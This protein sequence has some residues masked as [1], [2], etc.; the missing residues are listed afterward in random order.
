M[1]QGAGGAQTTATLAYSPGGELE[2]LAVTTSSSGTTATQFLYD[3]D[4]MVGEYN[5]GVLLRRYVRGAD[6]DEPLVWYDASDGFQRR[7]LHADERGSIIGWS[8]GSGVMR[9]TFT[10]GPYGEPSNWAGTRFAYTGQMAIPEVALYHDKAR[11]YDP[12]FGHF[13]QTD[14]IRYEGGAN[15]YQ[16]VG[17]DPINEADPTGDIQ[18][19]HMQW[20]AL[21]GRFFVLFT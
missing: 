5:S 2:Q 20:I 10:Y 7:W 12:A 8:D 19:R 13:L 11:V 3:G 18:G 15:L 21:L 14:P 9:A 6:A 4:Q 1:V 16:Y 17:G